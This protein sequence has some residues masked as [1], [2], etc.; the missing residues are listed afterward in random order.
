MLRD[1]DLHGALWRQLGFSLAVLA[2]EIP[3]GILL[4]L[5]MPAD[6]LEGLGWCWCCW[7]CRC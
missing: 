4:A 1:E 2:M 5:S 6:G 7:R 3:L